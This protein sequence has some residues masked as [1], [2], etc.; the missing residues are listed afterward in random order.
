[1]SGPHCNSPSRDQV[2]LPSILL[3]TIAHPTIFGYPG[4]HLLLLKKVSPSA[5]SLGY[6]DLTS[7][8]DEE[9]MEAHS[10]RV[11]FDELAALL[12]CR[13]PTAILFTD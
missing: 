8:P 2:T 13:L 7:E 9:M 3:I 12:I 4:I 1:M 11:R 10:R 5:A 6:I